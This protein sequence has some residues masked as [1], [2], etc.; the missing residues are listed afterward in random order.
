MTALYILLVE[1]MPGDAELARR[2]IDRLG[3]SVEL[4]VVDQRGTFAEELARREPDLI[5]SDYSLPSFSGMEALALAR[6]RYP[7]VPFV[8][9]TGS[10]NE[11]VAV[12]CMKAGADDYVLKENIQRLGAAV[13]TALRNGS[14]RREKAVAEENLRLALVEKETLLNE[15]HHRVRNNL[16]VVSGL[17][18]MQARERE[19]PH[20]RQAVSESQNRIMA[21][22]RV[23]EKLYQSR[24]L[25]HVTFDLYLGDLARHLLTVYQTGGGPI[26]LGE[27]LEP[28]LLPMNQAMPLALMA[29]E[30]LA[31]LLK[32]SFPGKENGTLRIALSTQPG[33]PPRGRLEIVGE[34]GDPLVSGSEE[35]S[36]GLSLV[37]LLTGQ[38]HARF[39]TRSGPQ[40]GFLVEFSLDPVS[41]PT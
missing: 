19:D 33:P 32:V 29:N 23:H 17:L 22:A 16:Q 1:D 14:L 39:E 10:I 5:V 21:M 3:F 41:R 9:L 26:L 25:S 31:H 8:I 11:E 15:I 4:V 13:Q 27:Q 6:E 40:P 37:R 28:M 38:I 18:T 2:Q 12:D 35:S 34:G 20:F 24:S 7:L 30:M 36:V